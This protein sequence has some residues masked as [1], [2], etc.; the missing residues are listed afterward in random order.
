MSSKRLLQAGPVIKNF[1][2]KK[3]FSQ[4]ELAHR[5]LK[6]RVG[7][8]QLERD[9]KVPNLTTLILLAHAFDMKPSELLEEIENYGDNNLFFQKL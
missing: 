5:C 3:N 8:S 1:R 4:E 7:I 6:D 2:N 9:I